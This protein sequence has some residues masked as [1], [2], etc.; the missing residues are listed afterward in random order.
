MSEHPILFNE[1]MIRA[2][3][4]GRKTMTRQR[5]NIAGKDSW[6]QNPWGWVIEFKRIEP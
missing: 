4:D 6:N 3:L 2:I 5:A 1:P